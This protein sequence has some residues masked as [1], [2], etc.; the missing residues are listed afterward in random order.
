MGPPTDPCSHEPA[1]AGNSLDARTQRNRLKYSRRMRSILLLTLLL[2]ACTSRSQL[3]PA[4][5]A[6]RATALSAV[7]EAAAQVADDEARDTLSRYYLVPPEGVA[8]TP[9]RKA[10]VE[11][12]RAWP[13]E[14][15]QA[16]LAW[17]SQ[18]A[19]WA[20]QLRALA[21]ESFDA[22]LRP[23]EWGPTMSNFDRAIFGRR[24]DLSPLLEAA[25][26]DPAIRQLA[27]GLEEVRGPFDAEGVATRREALMRYLRIEDTF[28]PF[29]ALSDPLLMPGNGVNAYLP[30]GSLL[31]V[32]GPTRRIEDA[33]MI[34][35]H[36][37]AHQPLNR[38]LRHDEVQRALASS[39]CVFEK[40]GGKLG[41]SDWPWLF[42]E[43]LARSLSYRL[44][45]V[46]YDTGFYEDE[47]LPHLERWEEQRQGTFEQTMV[48]MLEAMKQRHCG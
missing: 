25:Y 21:I 41:Y 26:G 23:T 27:R 28:P 40:L 24:A 4:G 38:M 13:D 11:T 22:K 8:A 2:C 34:L 47:L 30:D 33:S 14:R 44:Q 42:A 16:A 9:E 37:M 29:A 39:R 10:L 19:T 31:F 3:A 12:V 7:I 46:Q 43:S 20:T 32:V 5:P 15:K 1:R 17:V 35:F 18:N 45:G 6:A 36:E 48:A